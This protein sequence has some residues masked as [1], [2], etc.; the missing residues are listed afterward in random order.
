MKDYSKLTN[1]ALFN[2]L[3]RLHMSL[4]E[5]EAMDGSGEL[6]YRIYKGYEPFFNAIYAEMDK[7]GLSEN[8][9]SEVYLEDSDNRKSI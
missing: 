1:E 7:R 9:Y 3:D 2:E 5:D 8:D 4:E 6:A